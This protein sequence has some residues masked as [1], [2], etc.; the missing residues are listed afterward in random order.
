GVGVLQDRELAVHRGDPARYAEEVQRARVD[1]RQVDVLRDLDGVV[2]PL[3]DLRDFRDQRLDVAREKAVATRREREPR[4]PRLRY[5][6]VRA[7]QLLVQ[8]LVVVAQLE[9]LRVRG[10]DHVRDVA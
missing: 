5:A 3:G 2:D 6:R 9:E 1:A 10:L 8:Q 4:T 7:R